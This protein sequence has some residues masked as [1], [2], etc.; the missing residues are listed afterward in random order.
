MEIST[1]GRI[2]LFGE[3]QDYLG[4]PV[5]AMAISL[6]AQITGQKRKDQQVIIH[7][8]DIGETESFLLND[9]V[10]T[11][12]RD[13]FKSGIKICSGEELVF[14]NGFESEITSEIPIQ[15][16]V[17]SSSAVMVSWIY[18]LSRMAD[19]PVAWN[20]Q[21]IGELAYKAEV[22]EFAEP[23]GMMDQYSATMGHLL[24][25]ESEPEI[26][27][28]SLNPNLGIFVLGDSCEPKDTMSILQRCR[29]TR[30]E[31]IKK[32]KVK[33]PD[34]NIHT[35]TDVDMSPL[36]DEEKGIFQGT[37]KNRNILRQ[38]LPELEKVRPDPTCIGTRLTQHHAVLRD[39]LQVSTPKIEAM[40]DASL[41]AG[42]LGGKINGSGGGGCM[43]AYAPKNAE[44]VAEAIE[45]VGGKSFIISSDS[46]TRIV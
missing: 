30:L 45:K 38:A 16:G 31:I 5:V 7:K 6:R 20:A 4:L 42:A 32:L 26:S 35:C 29:D 3:H 39:I 43:F 44:I 22:L 14:S 28:K 21:K 25:L 10:Y 18:F 27:I 2:C 12:P 36:N 8:P 41:D 17:G 37:I 23:G 1:P 13:Y 9:L 34:F 19:T 33:N 15:A 40:L 24:Y 11:K 46:G